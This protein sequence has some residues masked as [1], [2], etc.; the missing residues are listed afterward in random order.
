MNNSIEAKYC[1][2]T[3][4][5]CTEGCLS[6]DWCKRFTVLFTEPDGP[7]ALESSMPSVENDRGN[8]EP[9]DET[10]LVAIGTTAL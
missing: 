5:D 8:L 6:G 7:M 9:R 3:G 10:L 4:G 1:P 2:A